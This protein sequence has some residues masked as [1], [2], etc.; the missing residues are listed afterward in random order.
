MLEEVQR[1]LRLIK[2]RNSELVSHQSP[3]V[4]IYRSN[5]V[6]RDHASEN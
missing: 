6:E 1:E 4:P 3:P 5:V 2:N